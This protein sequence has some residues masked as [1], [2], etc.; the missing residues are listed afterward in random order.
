MLGTLCA[1]LPQRTAFNRSSGGQE[2]VTLWG[3]EGCLFLSFF[4]P[5]VTH[6]HIAPFSFF[7]PSA[8]QGHGGNASYTRRRARRNFLWVAPAYR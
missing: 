1:S 4:F 5:I 3:V 2:L 6:F 7:P 8:V